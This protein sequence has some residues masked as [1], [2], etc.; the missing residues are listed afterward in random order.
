[1]GLNLMEQ[2]ITCQDSNCH[3]SFKVVR[4]GERPDYLYV[5]NVVSGGPCPY[6]LTLNRIMWTNRH[7][8]H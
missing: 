5:R 3:K 7:I 1:M 8:A 6:C 4:A 2:L